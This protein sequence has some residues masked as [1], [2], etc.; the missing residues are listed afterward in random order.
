MKPT[1][2]FLIQSFIAF[3]LLTAACSGAAPA[4]KNQA[5]SNA[6]AN[7]NTAQ[8]KPANS[9]STQPTQQANTGSIEVTSVPPGAGLTLV[10][11]YG[12]GA[13]TPRSYGITPATITDL[14]PGKYMVT[15]RTN[16]GYAQKEVEVA[17]GKTIQVNL[18]IKKQAT[19]G[20][21]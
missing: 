14:A 18:S 15:A 19:G 12:D 21:R 17:A 3:S 16:S 20:R 8:P 11:D 10:P 5:N 2:C 9:N 4:N 6:T 7:A 13:G 1:R